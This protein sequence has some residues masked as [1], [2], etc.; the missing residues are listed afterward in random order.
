MAGIILPSGGL[1]SVDVF[2]GRDA[3]QCICRAD[4]CRGGVL[5]RGSFNAGNWPAAFAGDR[6]GADPV[7]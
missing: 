4:L 2:P 5:G 6:L 7:E 3:T 1:L